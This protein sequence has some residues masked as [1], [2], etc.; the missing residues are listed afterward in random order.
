M[1]LDIGITTEKLYVGLHIGRRT[2][3][4]LSLHHSLRDSDC[5]SLIKHISVVWLKPLI[6][7]DFQRDDL[8]LCFVY[9][10]DSV[11]WNI[12]SSFPTTASRC[13]L[14][15]GIKLVW[16]RAAEGTDKYFLSIVQRTKFN[17]NELLF[18]Y[19]EK[20]FK[21]LHVCS[22]LSNLDLLYLEHM[23]TLKLNVKLYNKNHYGCV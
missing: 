14:M 18:S 19:S 10:N 22:W 8:D 2:W 16:A 6:W 17:R 20:I 13:Y 7:E 1:E 23:W 12:H 21:K 4:I 9:L 11:I 5:W 15:A 3:H